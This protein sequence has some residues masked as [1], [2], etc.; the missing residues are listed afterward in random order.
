[1]NRLGEI[2]A[3]E[4]FGPGGGSRRM[5]PIHADFPRI[6]IVVPSFNQA[7]FIRETLQ[8]LVDQ[9]YP[10]LEVI[11]QD[12]GST[13][14]AVD[15]AREFVARFPGTFQL[16][17]QKD[18]GHAH[19]LNM[20]FGRAT[21]E[22][23]GYLN[24]DDTLYPGCLRRVA[25]E[26]DPD[27]GRFIV[28]GRC[29]FTG[30]G[31]RYVGQEHPAEYR[32]HFDLLAVWTRGYN[33]IPQP[34][35]FWHRAVAE[36][37]GSFDER[38]NHGLDYLQWCRF[39][40][41]FR[42]HRVD[43][44]WSTYRM[45]PVSVTANKS[46][47]EWQDIMIRY[48]RMHWGPWW[49]PLRWR[50]EVSLWLHE[51]RLRYWIARS[52]LRPLVRAVRGGR[53]RAGETDAVGRYSDGWIGPVYRSAVDVPGDARRLILVLEHHPQA[54]HRRASPVLS[55]NGRVV[56]RQRLRR[57]GQFSFAVD[58][59]AYRRKSCTVEVRTPEFFIPRFVG[60]GRDDRRLSLLLLDQ[61][62]E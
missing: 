12:G 7:P 58:V 24:T 48:S 14:G 6:T 57:A 47:Q 35:T 22:I 2:Q 18:R 62:I 40:K 43:A 31:S 37:C 19:A 34:S 30:E 9:E 8:S 51:S 13:D 11:I 61:R 54:Y 33:S 38:Y 60:L 5:T 36:R 1:M 29:L 27:R 55:L 49:S 26:I 23:F 42:F 44:L 46:E 56:A 59:A 21:G 10:N 4:G 25:Q 32:G 50:C 52:P 17:V 3:I 15:V 20:A 41:H 28:F 39:S 45:H 16:Y 53:R